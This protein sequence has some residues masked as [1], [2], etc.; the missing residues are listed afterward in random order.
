MTTV[1]LT[2]KNFVTR[3]MLSRVPASG[4]VLRILA[5][6]NGST[7]EQWFRVLTVV[8]N[9]NTSEYPRRSAEELDA[10]VYCARIPSDF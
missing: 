10:W 1:E 3:A 8:H 5:T 7:V 2:T 4:E 9:A 6:E